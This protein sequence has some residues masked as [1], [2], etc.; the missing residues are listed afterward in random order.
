MRLLKTN[1]SRQLPNVGIRLFGVRTKKSQKLSEAFAL[2]ELLVIVA[3]ISLLTLVLMPA[4]A[5]NRQ[6]SKSAICLNNLRQIGAGLLMYASD[7]NDTLFNVSGS[8]PNGGQW[9]PSPAST[10]L[11]SPSSSDAY[12]GV[13]YINYV[14]NS[15]EVFRCPSARKVDEWRDS[16]LSYP[17]EFW[18]FSTYGLTVFLSQPYSASR[19]S[20]AKLHSVTS[21]GTMILAQDSA[22]SRMEGPDDTI[23]LFPGY[24][25]ILNQWI[26]TQGLGTLYG[27]Y[28]FQWEWYRHDQRCQTLFLSGGVSKIRFN[29]VNVGIDY[30]YYTGDKPMTSLP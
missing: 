14:G 2:S 11:I 29:G 25:Q 8:I 18:L 10:T 6:Q 1:S 15:R 17:S 12:W 22:E 4:L 9:Y 27:G 19:P 16:G 20:P 13:A 21:P 5:G 30:R 23:G 3:V 7:Y 24:A 28:E 26:G